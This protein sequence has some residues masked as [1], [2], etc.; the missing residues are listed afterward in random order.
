MTVTVAQTSNT[1]TFGYLIGVVNQLSNAMSTVAVTV[2]SNTAIGN[3]AING[4]FT[5]NSLVTANLNITNSSGISVLSVTAPSSSQISNGTFFLNANGTWSTAGGLGSVQQ[6][7]SG[8][9]T[10]TLDY[11]AMSTYNAAEYTISVKDEN[12]NNF[13][14]TK[15]LVMHD[16]ANPYIT[17]YGSL[18]SNSNMGAFTATTNST[19]LILQFTPVSSNTY[20][21]FARVII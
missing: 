7:T 2:N 14:A 17:E 13:Y 18:T 19:A 1:N 5:A 21:K 11:F 9:T 3:A 12:A 8:T 10:Q 20:V 4:T 6:F 15:L 16:G